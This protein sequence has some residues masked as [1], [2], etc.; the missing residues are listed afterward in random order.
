[1]RNF[2]HGQGERARFWS[3]ERD[4][5]RLLLSFG[6][7]GGTGRQR[8]IEHDSIREA[9]LDLEQRVREKL[10][11]GYVEVAA[12]T[13]LRQVLEEAL[14]ATP[15]DL[16]T[17][18]AYADYLSEQPDPAARARGEFIQVQLALEDPHRLPEERQRLRRREAELLRRH[19]DEWLGDLAGLQGKENVFTFARGWL[20]R[21]RI[22]KLTVDAARL[23]AA[24]PQ[25]RLMRR[26]EVIDCA[27]ELE[28][29]DYPREIQDDVSISVPYPALSVLAHSG[30]YLGNVRI[31]QLGGFD[32][33]VT[34]CH[35]ITGLAKLLER[36][37]LLRELH[38]ASLSIAHEALFASP[39]FR[40]LHTL[41]LHGFMRGEVIR[42]LI[43]SG[44]LG[45]LKVLELWHGQLTDA[46]ALALAQAKDIS[47]LELLDVS[48]NCL[49]ARGI[50]ALQRTGV[51]VV[52]KHQFE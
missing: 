18:M 16:A 51:R 27:I 4:G 22:R 39:V 28:G 2:Q 50:E 20:E 5:P 25:T 3:V 42:C 7:V 24:A 41:R 38:L 13:G 46:D 10:N 26:L 36:M 33:G 30:R 52:A 14:V 9:G 8:V 49:T 23:L 35:A 12:T 31:V 19:G 6:K 32:N 40:Q 1:M 44:V 43:R 47:N 21:A 17:H 34:F 37:P 45:S 29:R 11:E 48:V 15:D